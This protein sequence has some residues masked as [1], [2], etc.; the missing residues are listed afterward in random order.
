M[1]TPP[2]LDTRSS[3]LY[4]AAI[5][6]DDQTGAMTTYPGIYLWNQNRLVAA[7]GTVTDVRTS[8]LTPAWD[9]FQIPPV[10]PIIIK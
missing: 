6:V 5:V 7:D 3:Q 10:P 8:N 4:M 9:E 1:Y 2:T